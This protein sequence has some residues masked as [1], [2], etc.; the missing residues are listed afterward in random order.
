MTVNGDLSR[1]PLVSEQLRH[2]KIE[3]AR[4]YYTRIEAGSAGKRLR[5]I[6]MENPVVMH[7]NPVIRERIDYTGYG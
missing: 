6:W 5:D 1:L 4:N 7:E 3:T 2:S